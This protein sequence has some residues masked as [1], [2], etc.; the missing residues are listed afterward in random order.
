MCLYNEH[1]GPMRLFPKE[2]Q[3]QVKSHELSSFSEASSSSCCGDWIVFFSR[4]VHEKNPT[5]FWYG[6]PSELVYIDWIED[7]GEKKCVFE[8]PVFLC[9]TTT[10]VECT[11]LLVGILFLFGLHLIGINELMDS[12]SESDIKENNVL[13][14]NNK[15]FCEWD[16]F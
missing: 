6:I 8:A 7:K 13:A 10:R 15:A 16:R 2:Q 11:D 4:L 5:R 14:M 12:V 1:K 9:R 3:N